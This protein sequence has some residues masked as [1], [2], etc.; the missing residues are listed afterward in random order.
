MTKTFCDRCE[1][2]IE[3][4]GGEKGWVKLVKPEKDFSYDFSQLPLKELCK[5]CFT[6]LEL[7]LNN[8]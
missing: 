5:P 4:K 1:K 6:A 3:R 8:K 2:E 7:F